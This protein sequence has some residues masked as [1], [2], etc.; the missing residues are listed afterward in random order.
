MTGMG[1]QIVVSD[2]IA[3]AAVVTTAET[4]AATT[5]ALSPPPNTTV[6]LRGRVSLTAGT[7]TTAVT[8]RLRRGSGATGTSLGAPDAITA[9]AGAT[10][11]YEFEATDAIG[12]VAGQQWS[13]T[14]QQTG[15]S[16]NGT[17]VDAH[18]EAETVAD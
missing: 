17:I 11:E 3:N 6:I 4:V 13:L 18:I 2:T 16:A 14:V 7:G 15:A 1:R 9:T 8:V 10:G 12:D 5:P